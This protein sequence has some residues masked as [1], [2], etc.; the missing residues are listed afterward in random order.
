MELAIE[1][2]A[3]C[4]TRQEAYNSLQVTLMRR[5]IAQGGDP[6]EWCQSMAIV[7]NR[8]YKWML[9]EVR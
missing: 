7:F 9:A 1:Y 6:M 5:Y 4:K 3:R 8:R 2:M